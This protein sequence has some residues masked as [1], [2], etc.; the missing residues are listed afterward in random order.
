[1]IRRAP[2]CLLLTSAILAA[3]CG[4]DGP[5]WEDV[6]ERAFDDE[7]EGLPRPDCVTPVQDQVTFESLD[8]FDGI[9]S[10]QI[11]AVG[12]RNDCGLALLIEE[13]SLSGRGSASF[14]LR[15]GVQRGTRVAAGDTVWAQVGYAP[16][17]AGTH[18]AHLALALQGSEHAVVT[19]NAESRGGS[20][21]VDRSPFGYEDFVSVPPGCAQGK[22]WSLTS[23]GDVP[24]TVRS[25]SLQDAQEGHS[26][27]ELDIQGSEPEGPW[28]LAPGQ[29]LTAE[30][31]FAPI[32]TGTRVAFLHV[33]S[34]VFERPSVVVR[35]EATG[36]AAGD[37]DRLE[38]FTVDD[39]TEAHLPLHV[40]PQRGSIQ[41]VVAGSIWSEWSFDAQSNLL[42]VR[43]LPGTGRVRV[44]VRYAAE[45]P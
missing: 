37:L 21:D 1:M 29:T 44:D 10:E 36:R 27:W 34:D 45:C 28:V 31:R 24:V 35:L 2:A 3:G 11:Q 33:Q 25:V 12:F 16:R 18:E 39:A 38:T 43:G 13:R 23:T 17:T 4:K 7:E 32:G 42:T 20:L 40:A 15:G 30:V 5:S 9:D 22:A 26:P 19:I 14:A 8:L 41:V 6:E